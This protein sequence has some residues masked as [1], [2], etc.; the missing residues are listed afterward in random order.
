MN[1][2]PCFLILWIGALILWDAW[3]YFA[4]DP[5]WTVSATLLRW[6]LQWPFLALVVVFAV[7]LLIGHLFWPQ[8]S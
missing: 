6:A 7:G 2:T 1:P 8:R 4:I 5:N 3:L